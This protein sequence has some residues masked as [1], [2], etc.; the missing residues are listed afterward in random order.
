MS[1]DETPRIVDRNSKPPACKDYSFEYEGITYPLF[2]VEE[3]GARNVVCQL[4]MNV[5]KRLGANVYATKRG[6]IGKYV[7][8]EVLIEID[9]FFEEQ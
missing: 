1:S 2:T 4:P 3:N 6:E 8:A 5:P 9:K 7:G